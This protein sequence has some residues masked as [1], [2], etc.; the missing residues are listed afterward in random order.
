MNTFGFVCEMNRHVLK[1]CENLEGV[2]LW[3]ILSLRCNCRLRKMT[4]HLKACFSDL[5]H[6]CKSTSSKLCV[7]M[8]MCCLLI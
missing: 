3:T 6:N 7:S 1:N 5:D 2:L 4:W 8:G